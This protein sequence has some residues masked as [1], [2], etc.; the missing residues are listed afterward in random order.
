MNDSFNDLS[1]VHLKA[2][3]GAFENKREME[4]RDILSERSMSSVDCDYIGGRVVWEFAQAL[5]KVGLD[6]GVVAVQDH[7]PMASGVGLLSDELRLV[8]THETSYTDADI[9]YYLKNSSAT[10]VSNFEPQG[11]HSYR[12]NL[13]VIRHG[14]SRWTWKAWKD[15]RDTPVM[16]CILE[17]VKVQDAIRTNQ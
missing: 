10:S 17:I 16:T 11:S 9:V 1:S 3:R 15:R 12:C 13:K 14:N 2:D 4:L 5:E 6:A 7:G 8:I